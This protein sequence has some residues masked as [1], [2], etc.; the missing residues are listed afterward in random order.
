M[1]FG[2]FAG[3]FIATTAYDGQRVYGSTALGDFGRFESNGPQVCAP[4]NPRDLPFQ[5]PTV[6]ALDARSGKVIWQAEGAPSFGPTTVAGG[7]TF[8]GTALT[9]KVLVREA[10][11]GRVVKEIVVSAPCW[12]GVVTRPGQPIRTDL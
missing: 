6:H 9:D 2:G 10:T 5:E 3:G 1:V 11:S 4:G 12:S 8:N 7:L